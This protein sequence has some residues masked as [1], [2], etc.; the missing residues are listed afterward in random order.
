MHYRI[1]LLRADDHIGRAYD[2]ECDSDEQA[3][4]AIAGVIGDFPSAEVWCGT[5]H[6]GN[7]TPNESEGNWGDEGPLLA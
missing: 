1:Y 7:W 6:V 5:R 3:Y 2:F 4:D